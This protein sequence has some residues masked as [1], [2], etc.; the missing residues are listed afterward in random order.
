MGCQLSAAVVAVEL[1][2][3]V[4]ELAGVVV[5]GEA[6]LDVPSDAGAAG[7]ALLLPPLK[8]V[9]YQP[10]PLSWKPAAVNCFLKLGLPQAGQSE[11]RGSEIFCKR[12][13]HGRRTHTC[14]RK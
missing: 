9:S 1:A 7:V 3:V 6:G 11:S 13:W 14:R 10:P 5:A 12:P 2:E 8:S 4:L